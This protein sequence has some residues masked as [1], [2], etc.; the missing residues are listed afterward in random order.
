MASGESIPTPGE[1]E[2]VLGLHEEGSTSAIVPDH[3]HSETSSPL[4]PSPS[5][6]CPPTSEFETGFQPK[7]FSRFIHKTKRAENYISGTAQN[8]SARI[9]EVQQLGWLKR[10]GDKGEAFNAT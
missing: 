1:D 7:R 4:T 6:P 9:T 8:Q 2:K 5:K 3:F 10:E